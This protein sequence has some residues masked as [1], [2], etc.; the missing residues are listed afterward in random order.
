[1]KNPPPIHQRFFAEL[2]RRRVFRVMAFY[3]AASFA[4]LQGVDLLVPVLGLS[5]S[6]IQGV[7]VLL[8]IGAPVAI[9]LEWA[10]ELTPVQSR[11]HPSRF[12]PS[13]T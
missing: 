12:Y 10:F 3:G 11:R 13:S 9:V 6:V 2:K 1:M 8:L 4:V 5:D 7:A